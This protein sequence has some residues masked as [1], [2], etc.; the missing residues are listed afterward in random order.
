MYFGFMIVILLC[1]DLRHVSAAH[2][3]IFR[4]AGA[5]IQLY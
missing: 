4:V 5:K 1:T 3:V 2:M